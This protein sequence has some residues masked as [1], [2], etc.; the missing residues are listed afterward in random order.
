MAGITDDQLTNWFTYHR[1]TDED[2]KNYTAITDA[3]LAFARVVRDHT[4]PG[5]DQSAALR[6][7]REARMTANA[8][9]ACKGT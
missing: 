7:I 2:Q 1:P 4:P 3:A 9:V 5:A 6:Q 8:A